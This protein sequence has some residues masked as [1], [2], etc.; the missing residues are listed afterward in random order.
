MRR[1]MIG[2]AVLAVAGAARGEFFKI[3]G[4]VDFGGVGGNGGALF[5]D[6]ADPGDPFNPVVPPE[7]GPT[8]NG[9]PASVINSPGLSTTSF[10][11]IYFAIGGVNSIND[12]AGF[13]GVEI[14]RGGFGADY[15]LASEARV[16][17]RDNGADKNVRFTGFGMPGE[18][19]GGGTLSQ[20]YRLMQYDGAFR[21]LWVEA[22][23]APGAIALLA[24][25][26]LMAARRRW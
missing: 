1:M 24:P 19:V 7:F 13:D 14:F 8:A 18:V 17:I 3:Q 11:G 12:P 9:Q 10:A 16:L 15:A 2:A 22:I 26:G 5:G 21:S 6:F 23:P 4:A 25:M 20:T